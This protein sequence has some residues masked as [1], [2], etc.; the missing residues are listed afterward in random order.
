ME[1]WVALS[2]A[3]AFLQNLRSALQKTLTTRV[4]VLGA[5][6]A[7]FVFAAP[8]ALALVAVLFGPMGVPA[9]IPTA[10]FRP[11]RSSGR[12][13]R[14]RRRCSSCASSRSATSR[15]ATPSPR[16]RPCR[17]R[18]SARSCSAIGSGRSA[19]GRHPRR[20]RRARAPLRTRGLAAGLSGPAA[21]LGIAAGA[22][23][24]LASSATARPPGARRPAAA[25][26]SA[27]RLHARLRDAAPDRDDGRLDGSARAALAAARRMADGAL[28]GAAGMPPRLGWFMASRL[29]TAALV[30][31]VGQV[32]LLFSWLTS[33]LAFRER[34]SRARPSASR[35]C[36]R[37][38]AAGADAVIARLVGALGGRVYERALAAGVGAE[39]DAV[40]LARLLRLDV[41]V[42]GAARS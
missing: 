24:A 42:F 8:W 26:W 34:P 29:P 25:S 23:F 10:A 33:R 31:A 28:V 14:S 3:A 19:V 21:G 20:P 41:P 1:T 13:P 11:G 12:S 39:A 22:A 5:T 15:S 9:P 6:Y 16:P 17:P 2:V 18:S 27:R 4:G 7:R 36:R 30:K 38:R 32:E 35:W 40:A 37:D